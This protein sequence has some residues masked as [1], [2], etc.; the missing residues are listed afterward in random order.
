MFLNF[1]KNIINMHENK[2]IKLN[3]CP[4][5]HCL[6]PPPTQCSLHLLL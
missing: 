4:Q 2:N 6:L 3:R 5:C 1:N